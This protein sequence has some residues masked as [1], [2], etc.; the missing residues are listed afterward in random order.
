MKI[1]FHET[2]PMESDA[3]FPVDDKG[4]VMVIEPSFYGKAH[5]TAVCV[6]S[7]TTNKGKCLGR[8]RLKATDTGRLILEDLGE[9]RV[10]A[11]DSPL[12]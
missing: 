12:K 2:D 9:P 5:T 1:N 4:T 8:Y 3:A 11:I 7:T 6:L 10:L